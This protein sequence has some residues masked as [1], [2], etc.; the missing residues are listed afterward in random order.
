MGSPRRPRKKYSKPSH[1]WQKE[2][3]EEEKQFIEEYGLKNKQEI[4]RVTSLLK[5]FALQAKSLIVE[6]SVQ[7]EIEKSQLLKKLFSLGLI[8]QNAELEG[9]LSITVKN[10]LDRRLQTLVYKKKLARS[11]SQARQFIVH[12]HILIADRK[13]I[14]PSYLVTREEEAFISFVP[15]SPLFNQDHP[16]RV[17]QAVIKKEEKPSK[18]EEKPSKKKEAKKTEEKKKPKGEKK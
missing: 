3:I 18:K 14:M 11:I 10:I 2:R 16:E 7:A 4:W 8:E 12:R 6:T 17:E 13:I 5:K 1:P 15:K 9:V